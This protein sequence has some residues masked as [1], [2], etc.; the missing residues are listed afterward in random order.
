MVYIAFYAAKK[1]IGTEQDMPFMY[2][3]VP[4]AAGS[5]TIAVAY[6]VTPANVGLLGIGAGIIARPFASSIV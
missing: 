6:A 2:A 5:R 1:S 4:A 3:G